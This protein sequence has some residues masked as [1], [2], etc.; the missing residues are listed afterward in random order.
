MTI[1]NSTIAKLHAAYERFTGHKLKL[2]GVYLREWAWTEWIKRGFT[3]PDLELVV[4]YLQFQIR[5]D[6]RRPESL[7]FRNLIQEVDRFEEDLNMARDWKR[8]KRPEPTARQ[9]ILAATGR[10]EEPRKEPV[11][12][13]G[14]IIDAMEWKKWAEETRKGL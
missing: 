1:P 12:R 4:R 7:L 11:K 3:E 8:N 10:P 2:D 14:D 5:K 6:L 9:E 13:A